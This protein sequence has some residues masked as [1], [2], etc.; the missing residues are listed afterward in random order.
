MSNIA[1]RVI[2]ITGAARGIGQLLAS[3]AAARGALVVACDIN[4]SELQDVVG[5]IIGGGGKAVSVRADVTKADDM[6]SAARFAVKEFGQLDVLVNNAGIMPLAYFSDHAKAGNAWSRCIDINLKGVI[7]GVSAV[8]DQMFEQ[9]RGH[10]V[11]I[12]SIFANYPTKGGTVYGATKAAINYLSESLRQETQ[13]KIKV[14]TVRPTAIPST[15]LNESVINE[16]A[17]MGLMGNN[18]GE[19]LERLT[20]LTAGQAQPAWL[21]SESIEYLMMEPEPLVDQILYAIDQ[22]WGVSI[23]DLTVRASGDLF[24]V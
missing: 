19:M 15:S 4:E 2:L 10:V 6:Y 3:R 16:A 23:S 14:T 18:A 1:N 8:Y 5:S 7:N 24:V 9:G 20:T 22:P 21:D 17:P 12:S 13:G 11:N